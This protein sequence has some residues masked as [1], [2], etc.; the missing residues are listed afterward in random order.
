MM[1][2]P[3]GNHLMGGGCCSTWSSEN[4]AFSR[5]L[6]VSL[7]RWQPSPMCFQVGSKTCCHKKAQLPRGSAICSQKKNTPPCER[8]ERVT[9]LLHSATFLWPHA[10]PLTK[11]DQSLLVEWEVPVCEFREQRASCSLLSLHPLT[12]TSLLEANVKSLRWPRGLPGE[13]SLNDDQKDSLAVGRQMGRWRTR[14]TDLT[15]WYKDAPPEPSQRPRCLHS[16]HLSQHP[17]DTLYL[18]S[19]LSKSFSSS[20]LLTIPSLGDLTPMLGIYQLQADDFQI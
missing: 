7:V 3:T 6:Q 14:G 19:L 12:P 18:G 10:I 15:G 4:W 17:R 1:W 16:G 9:Y 2:G 13:R 5:S 11:P 8:R 20:F